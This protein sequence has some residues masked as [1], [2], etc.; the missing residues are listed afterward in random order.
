MNSRKYDRPLTCCEYTLYY[1]YHI[2]Y[3]VFISVMNS[4]T[5]ILYIDAMEKCLDVIPRS[6]NIS[7]G[8]TGMNIYDA[9]NTRILDKH[10]TNSEFSKIIQKNLSCQFPIISDLT[11]DANK[12]SVNIEKEPS[13]LQKAYSYIF[14][15]D[16]DFY[17]LKKVEN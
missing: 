12:E 7:Y 11:Q 6:N 9:T 2:L 3:G 15:S 16:A 1:R 4:Y 17:K 8:Y 13:I 5:M 10:N 14:Y